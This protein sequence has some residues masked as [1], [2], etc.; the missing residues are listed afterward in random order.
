VSCRSIAQPLLDKGLGPSRLGP[1]L[2]GKNGNVIHRRRGLLVPD[3]HLLTNWK[4]TGRCSGRTPLCS[5]AA[6]S[7]PPHR[8]HL[9]NRSC[10]CP[11][12]IAFQTRSRT[13]MRACRRDSAPAMGPLWPVATSVK[14]S[15]PGTQPALISKQR[16]RSATEAAGMLDLRPRRPWAGGSALGQSTAGLRPAPR[17]SSPDVGAANLWLAR[18]GFGPRL[19]S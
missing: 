2:D 19:N 1:G 14:T 9:P 15:A 16:T 10:G 8:R 5:A 4:L 12:C 6:A 18:G 7:M 17:Q 3:G 13:A 11:R